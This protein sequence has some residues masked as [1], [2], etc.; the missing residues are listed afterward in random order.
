[1]THTYDIIGLGNA[2]MDVLAFASDE[3][4][5]DEGMAKGRMMLID[6]AR[7][8]SLH[9]L[10]QDTKKLPGGSVANTLVAMADLG[11][12]ASFV[13]KLRDDAMGKQYR[14]GMAHVGVHFPTPE[15]HFGPSTACCYILVTPDGQ[16]TMN[17]YLGVCSEVDEAD[18]NERDVAASGLLYIEGYLWDQP[19]AKA[20]IR[21]GI[22]AAK[23]AGRQVALSLSDAFCI[24][25][26]RADFLELI[27]GEVDILFANEAEIQSLCENQD[28]EACVEQMR[29]KLTLAALTRAE[30]GSVLVT[31]ERRVEIAPV[32]VREVI[33][34]TGAG[35]LYAA[36]ILYGFSRGWSLEECGALGS[37]LA[38]QIIQQIGARSKMSLKALLAA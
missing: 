21:K 37:R 36:G 17:T 28:F 29:G 26:H 34:T 35:D 13:G 19:S 20:A 7:A 16:R 31:P 15:Q 5:D 23:A 30:R 33:D 32:P 4:L 24:E 6:E 2:I 27:E 1:M 12:K 3:F 25:R 22:R 14:Q 10:M 18:V 9:M 8:Q 11:A 38:A